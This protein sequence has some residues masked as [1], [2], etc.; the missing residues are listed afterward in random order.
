MLVRTC[1][2]CLLWGHGTIVRKNEIKNKL[3]EFED[4]YSALFAQR[5][6]A[7]NNWWGVVSSSLPNHSRSVLLLFVWI[8]FAKDLNLQFHL[9]HVFRDCRCLWWSRLFVRLGVD[10]Q[11]EYT[12]CEARLNLNLTFIVWARARMRMQSESQR[13]R[14]AKAFD[15]FIFNIYEKKNIW[16]FSW[17]VNPRNMTD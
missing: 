1:V 13:V 14:S 8:V 16:R 11:Y 12:H 2:L 3:R 4:W 10:S 7:R 17:H 5:K 9:N 15:C 6:Q